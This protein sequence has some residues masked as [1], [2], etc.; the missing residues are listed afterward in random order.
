[1]ALYVSSEGLMT[2]RIDDEAAYNEL[3]VDG[4]KAHSLAMAA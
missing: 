2:G 3:D 4:I 1:M